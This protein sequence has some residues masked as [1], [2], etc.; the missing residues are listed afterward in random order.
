MDYI[1][2]DH[3]KIKFCISI[4]LTIALSWMSSYY[5]IKYINLSN[6]WMIPMIFTCG[7]LIYIFINNQNCT[8][9]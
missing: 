2:Y 9:F 1:K 6:Q 4:L 5:F 8:N 3:K 7:M